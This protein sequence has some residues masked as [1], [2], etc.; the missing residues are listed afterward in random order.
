MGVRAQRRP[1]RVPCACT[2]DGLKCRMFRAVCGESVGR[3]DCEARA[4]ARSECPALKAP[5][6]LIARATNDK[7]VVTCLQQRGREVSD[8]L[9]LT[10]VSKSRRNEHHAHILGP[11]TLGLVAV[12]YDPSEFTELLDKV[13]TSSVGAGGLS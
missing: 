5:L 3:T 1:D 11:S 6:E 9:L 10:T 8:V 7:N 12:E 2:T 4:K 13:D